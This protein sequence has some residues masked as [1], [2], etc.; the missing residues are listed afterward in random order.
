MRHFPVLGAESVLASQA[1][2]CARRQ[3]RFWDYNDRLFANQRGVE[4]GAFSPGN[5]KR[6]AADLGLD[7]ARFNACVDGLETGALVSA[8]REQGVQLGVTGTP[9]FLVSGQLVAGLLPWESFK[10][11]IDKALRPGG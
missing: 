4:R 10:A 7:T 8:Q 2:E 9:S 6:F 11:L 1:A 3:D 5:L